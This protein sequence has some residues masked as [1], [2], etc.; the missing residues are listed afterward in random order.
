MTKA[1]AAEILGYDYSTVAKYMPVPA[2]GNEEEAAKKF[3][4]AVRAAGMTTHD[5]S[6]DELTEEVRQAYVSLWQ[7]HEQEEHL[8]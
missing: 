7:D 4:S 1:Q 2:A 3:H 6:W 8:T 5:Q